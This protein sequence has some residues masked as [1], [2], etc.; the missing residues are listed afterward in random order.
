V[1]KE[2]AF[3]IAEKVLHSNGLNESIRV[4]GESLEANRKDYLSFLKAGRPYDARR[5]EEAMFRDKEVLMVLRDWKG[6]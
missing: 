2:K 4:I 3:E 1:S 6:G 5:A